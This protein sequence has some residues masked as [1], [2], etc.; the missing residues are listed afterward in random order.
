MTAEAA[1]ITMSDEERGGGEIIVV[2]SGKNKAAAHP[3]NASFI[4]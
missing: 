2:G 3:A 4:F 1:G